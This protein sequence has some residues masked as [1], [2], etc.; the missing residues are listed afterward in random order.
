[1]R[2]DQ[3]LAG[4][5]ALAHVFLGACEGARLRNGA[6]FFLGFAVAEHDLEKGVFLNLGKLLVGARG[7]DLLF[8]LC[9]LGLF[10]HGVGQHGRT[11]GLLDGC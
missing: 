6:A 8:L 9:L 4:L 3:L 2:R 11:T 1:M 7:F 10:H 5:L